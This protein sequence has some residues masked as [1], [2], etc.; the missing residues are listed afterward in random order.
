MCENDNVLSKE[1]TKA[2]LK[3]LREKVATIRDITYLGSLLANM[4]V[5]RMIEEKVPL[6]P[7]NKS[8]Y[9]ACFREVCGNPYVTSENEE[10]KVLTSQ[11]QEL[12]NMKIKVAE[13]YEEH[14]DK[15]N[16]MINN[17]LRFLSSKNV[18]TILN[19][20]S[21]ELERNLKVHL[22]AN[23]EKVRIKLIGLQIKKMHP[24]MPISKCGK[25][26]QHLFKL[27]SNV[28][29][30]WPTS[31]AYD[32]NLDKDLA[33]LVESS[34]QEFTKKKAST[35]PH[36]LIADLVESLKEIK[37]ILEKEKLK[38]NEEYQ[39]FIDRQW[40]NRKMKKLS[41]FP[42]VST[43]FK[44]RFRH[45]LYATVS[46]LVASIPTS[47]TSSSATSSSATSSSATSS[48]A[49]DPIET[50]LLN[51]CK[52]LYETLPV[53]LLQYLENDKDTV[54]CSLLFKPALK[55]IQGTFMPKKS[56]VSKGT[57]LF[58]ITPIHSFQQ[59]SITI[60]K[61][62]LGSILYNLRL[63]YP[64]L[65]PTEGV[66]DNK[67]NYI[68]WSWKLF[69][70]KRIGFNN[71]QKLRNKYDGV[72]TTDGYSISFIF[73]RTVCD[74]SIAPTTTAPSTS[75][76]ATPSTSTTAPSTSIAPTAETC[77]FSTETVPSTSIAAT[78]STS[79]ATTGSR[80]TANATAT[81]TME[82]MIENNSSSNGYEQKKG[83]RKRRK[84]KKKEKEIEKVN[85]E[86]ALVKLKS[87]ITTVGHSLNDIVYGIDPGKNSL[88][89]AV[90]GCDNSPY[91]VRTLTSKEFY[92][93]AGHHKMTRIRYY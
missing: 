1:S 13:T 62:S 2:V 77:L 34:K 57:R 35:T 81:N 15:L 87:A 71:E 49:T 31:V 9:D 55:I 3:D 66:R 70:F 91:Q 46:N 89:T 21:K 33:K 44:R 76:A 63:K 41:C 22:A 75:I 12:A 38:E 80:F 52:R 36:L 28:S 90:S 40:I 84:K 4:H 20:S 5:L 24:S 54:I 78:P 47:A 25:L 30:D 74:D 86:N 51:E 88:I 17:D 23:F 93:H 83:K 14:F 59:R 29:T 56:M 92:H 73:H 6:H 50:L 61:G 58:K 39:D 68:S 26:A 67:F 43:R 18:S 11:K 10:Q 27:L 42:K 85:I 53:S 79:I 16:G 72:F 69:D 8:F 32:K 37:S 60:D 19:H 64:D 65:N 7:I 45:Y 48:S 82:S